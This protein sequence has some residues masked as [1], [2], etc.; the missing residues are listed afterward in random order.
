MTPRCQRHPEMITQMPT[1]PQPNSVGLQQRRLDRTI[2]LTYR[3]KV[4]LY[5]IVPNPDQPRLGPKEDD[6]LQ[7]QIEANEGLFEP[8]LVE[9]HPEFTGKYVIIYGARR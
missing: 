8:L 5:D 2:F 4:D 7:R 9:P 6:E 1:Q 3:S